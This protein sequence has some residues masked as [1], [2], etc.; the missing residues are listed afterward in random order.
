MGLW[1]A[2]F[3]DLASVGIAVTAGQREVLQ[4]GGEVLVIQGLPEPGSLYCQCGQGHPAFDGETGNRVMVAAIVETWPVEEPCPTA[5]FRPAG[6]WTLADVLSS[7]DDSHWMFWPSYAGRY[8]HT[9]DSQSYVQCMYEDRP[10]AW[11]IWDGIPVSEIGRDVAERIVTAT[12]TMVEATPWYYLDRM[13]GYLESGEEP[14]RE[15]FE[16][17]EYDDTDFKE[18]IVGLEECGL[19][20]REEWDFATANALDLVYPS[21]TQYL[22][23]TEASV[24]EELYRTSYASTHKAARTI[25]KG[26]RNVYQYNESEYSAWF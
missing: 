11:R 19:W 12:N 9:V 17:P 5:F 24:W 18:T 3:D 16:D 25:K 21:P 22:S 20:N 6:C 4:T 13:M 15:E 7:E 10:R 14:T 26:E 1:Q 8:E 2:N 23:P